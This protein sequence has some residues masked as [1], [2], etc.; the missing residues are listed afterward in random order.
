M[1]LNKLSA[2]YHKAPLTALNGFQFITYVDIYRGNPTMA[3]A[4]IRGWV[5]RVETP[6]DAPESVT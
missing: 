6:A 1:A 2:T 4:F 5:R 3:A